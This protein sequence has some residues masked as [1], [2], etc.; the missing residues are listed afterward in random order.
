MPFP[1]PDSRNTGQPGNRRSKIQQACVLQLPAVL[2]VPA[3]EKHGNCHI[4]RTVISM[5]AVMAAM[6]SGDDDMVVIASRLINPL[7][8]GK[9]VAELPQIFGR[10][11]TMVVPSLFIGFHQM[12]KEEI[13]LLPGDKG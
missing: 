3:A 4:L 9:G 2:E 1:F 8:T 7:G 5:A 12:Q 11:P 10:H 6:I 13:R